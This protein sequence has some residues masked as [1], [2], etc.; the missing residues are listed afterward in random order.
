MRMAQLAPLAASLSVTQGEEATYCL[1]TL[2]LTPSSCSIGAGQVDSCARTLLQMQAQPNTPFLNFDIAT[3]S[4]AL[5]CI[6]KYVVLFSF[7][8]KHGQRACLV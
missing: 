2:L 6:G 5:E 8:I 4:L 1:G 7:F 3:Q